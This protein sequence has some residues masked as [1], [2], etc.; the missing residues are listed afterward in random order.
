MCCFTIWLYY[1]PVHLVLSV[2]LPLQLCFKERY[3]RNR[4]RCNC[5]CGDVLRWASCTFLTLKFYI[6]PC[7]FF[8]FFRHQNSSAFAIFSVLSDA[9]SCPNETGVLLRVDHLEST[10]GAYPGQAFAC[11]CDKRCGFCGK[12]VSLQRKETHFTVLHWNLF[13]SSLEGKMLQHKFTRNWCRCCRPFLSLTL[14]E[15]V[16]EPAAASEHQTQRVLSSFP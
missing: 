11:S 5:T 15:S 12:R 7:F 16:T 10:F 8:M 4:S 3:W 14:P 9:V 6:S 1:V 2:I 13:T